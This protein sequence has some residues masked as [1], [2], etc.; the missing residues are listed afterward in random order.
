MPIT[1]L[2][3]DDHA[4]LREGLAVLLASHADIEV[5]GTAANGREALAQVLRLKP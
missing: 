5:V 3:S 1:V 4:I 2:I